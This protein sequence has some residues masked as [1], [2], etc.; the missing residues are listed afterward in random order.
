[1]FVFRNS[2]LCVV[3]YSFSMKPVYV[4]IRL[5]VKFCILAGFMS[6]KNPL[7]SK[8]ICPECFSSAL[9]RQWSRSNLTLIIRIDLWVN[10]KST[11]ILKQVKSHEVRLILIWTGQ[12]DRLHS[13][14]NQIIK[15][16]LSQK[17]VLGPIPTLSKQ[18]ECR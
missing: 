6:N 13:V 1:M 5:H 8:L 3:Y 17:R 15:R 7:E 9:G 4:E 10:L 12:H 14:Q 11:I 16:N 2:K 18:K